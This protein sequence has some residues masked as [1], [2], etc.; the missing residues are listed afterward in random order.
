MSKL[1][2]QYSQFTIDITR[3]LNKNE[4]KEHGIFITPKIIIE[5][6]FHSIMN[7]ISENGIIIKTILEPSCGTC[8]IVNYCD[9]IFNG[10]HIDAIEF[11]D[12][13]FERINSLQF[14]NKV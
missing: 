11:N 1:I 14:K 9:D 8:E 4:K 5:K 13:I 2:Q 7:F 3:E 12:K 10:I 6:L